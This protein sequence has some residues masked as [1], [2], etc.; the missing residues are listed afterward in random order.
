MIAQERI[1]NGHGDLML[2]GEL[3]IY[4]AGELKNKLEQY[5]NP[6]ICQTMTIDMSDVVEI[7]T[8]CVQI[9]MQ[10]KL[11]FK[12]TGRELKIVSHSAVVVEIFDLYDL[13]S[14]FGDPMVLV[15]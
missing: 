6:N 12:N 2:N 1:S 15:N 4:V 8:S 7:D 14:F 9:L 3:T 5:T 10:L 13:C 11:E